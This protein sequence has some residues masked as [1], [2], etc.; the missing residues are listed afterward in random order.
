MWRTWTASAITQTHTLYAPMPDR[1][2]STSA[3]GSNS[4]WGNRIHIL[5]GSSALKAGGVW[6]CWGPT[7]A[8]LYFW[9]TAS[10]YN[11]TLFPQQLAPHRCFSKNMQ[12]NTSVSRI[13][14]KK[15]NS[16]AIALDQ[17]TGLVM[18]LLPCATQDTYCSSRMAYKKVSTNKSVTVCYFDVLHKQWYFYQ[19]KSVWTDS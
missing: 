7:A 12:Q 17:G 1:W 16:T 9:A 4:V 6:S 5:T 15:F 13:F 2:S 3:L 14:A 18:E 11:L 10:H 8:V 19:P